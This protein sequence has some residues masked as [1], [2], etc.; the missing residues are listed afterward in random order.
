MLLNKSDHILARM[1]TLL[2]LKMVK[3]DYQVALQWPP[4]GKVFICCYRLLICRFNLVWT[5]SGVYISVICHSRNRCCWASSQRM[6]CI[7][8]LVLLCC[9]SII[10]LVLLLYLSRS[11]LASY[12]CNCVLCSFGLCVVTRMFLYDV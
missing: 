12:L 8:Q 11:V 1:C 4:T 6:D 7:A 9:R 3:A 2:Y 10:I 5:V